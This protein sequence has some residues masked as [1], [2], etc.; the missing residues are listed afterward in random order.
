MS[1]IFKPAVKEETPLLIGLVGPSGSGKTYSALRLATGIQQVTGGKIMGI[2]TEARRML[3]YANRFKFDYLELTP[4]FSSLRYLEA[5]KVAVRQGGEKSI[6]IVDSMSHEHEG[7]NGYLEYHETELQRL[8][9]DDYKK[10]ERNN[11]SAWIR[12]AGDRRKLINGLLQLKASFIFCFRAKEKLL[13]LSVDG[14]TKP[15]PIGW[16]AIAGEEFVYEMGVRCLL[17]PGS[18]GTP[19]WSEDSQKHGVPKMSED[20]VSIFSQSKSLDEEIGKRLAEWASGGVNQFE[21]KPGEPKIIPVTD[22]HKKEINAM[23]KS[24]GMNSEDRLRF[25]NQVM[26][27]DDDDLAQA[28]ISRF[29]DFYHAWIVS[30][31]SDKGLP[32]EQYAPGPCPLDPEKTMLANYC[33][34]NCADREGCAVWA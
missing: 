6:V 19:D 18:N 23:M 34:N 10:R 30:Q 28:F 32:D 20:H 12:P 9:G 5:L 14:K 7:A 27:A 25:Y 24:E 29:E 8:A 13:L 21:E 26:R 2:D 11:F 33:E 31:M 15:V 16:Q 1:F 22:A 4:P 17:P 3:H